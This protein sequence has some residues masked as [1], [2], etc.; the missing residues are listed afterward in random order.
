MCSLDI[1]H[2]GGGLAMTWRICDIGQKILQSA[3][4]TGSKSGHMLFL[5]A[6]LEVE[7]VRYIINIPCIYYNM[8]Q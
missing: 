2:L 6:F 3:I 1:Y 7:F 8:L 4:P 5:I